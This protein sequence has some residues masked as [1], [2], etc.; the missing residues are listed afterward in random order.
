MVAF[1]VY[2]NGKKT[3]TAGIGTHGILTTI[4]SLATAPPNRKDLGFT[5]GGLIS[6]RREHLRWTERNIRVGDEI[7]VKIVERTAV[8]RPRTRKRRNPAQALRAKKR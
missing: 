6:P 8:D 1:E 3:C 2:L 7:R 5:V 4:P